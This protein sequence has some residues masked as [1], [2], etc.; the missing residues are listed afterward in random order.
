MLCLGHA[1]S[2]N[3]SIMWTPSSL[4]KPHRFI[5]QCGT[6]NVDPADEAV[7]INNFAF[8]GA[9]KSRTDWQSSCAILASTVV[10]EQNDNQGTKGFEN[11][12]MVNG[13]KYLELVENRCNFPKPLTIN[14]MS[15]S[16]TH[17]SQIRVAYQGVPGAYSETAA[18]KAYPNCES[19]P[20]DQ[21]EVAFQAVELWIADH[22]VLPIENS[23]GGSIHRNYDLLL[24]HRLHIVGE[25][26]LPVRH[27]LLALP[28]IMSHIC[29]IKRIN[30]IIIWIWLNMTMGMFGM[31][32]LKWY[33]VSRVQV[34]IFRY[35][36]SF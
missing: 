32:F 11:I 18:G 36:N 25:V 13:D 28:G 14:D 33:E 2:I 23:L 9:S 4:S 24:R 1:F 22:A 35:K 3:K 6:N 16:Q 10:A 15:H 21:F 20:C 8:T 26:Q 7:R 30:I 27:C 34:F 5:V 12:T 17:G 31:E 29:K 19:I